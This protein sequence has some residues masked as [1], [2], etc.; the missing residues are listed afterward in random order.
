MQ[1]IGLF[2]AM[3]D[4]DVFRDVVHRARSIERDHRD[5]ILEPGRLQLAQ[6]I[7]HAR[8]L[9]LEHPCRIAP[10]HQLIGRLVIKLELVEF[11]GNIALGHQVERSLEDGQRGQAEEVELDQPGGFHVLHVE[12][13]HPHIRARVTIERYQLIERSIT[14]HDTGSV[15]RGVAVQPLELQGDVE[16]PG[17]GRLFPAHFPQG[18]F[19]VNGFLQGY[20]IGRIVRDQFGNPVN[21]PVRHLQDAANITH[22]HPGLKLTE[23]DNLRDP[24]IAVFLA[25]I[26]DHLI[27]AMLTEID[28]EIGH[29]YPFGIEEALE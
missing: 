22:H 21:L 5:N 14:D 15:G 12:L 17:N 9:K 26:I 7:A 24:V 10:R 27:P 23:G 13:R 20:R 25:H 19:T 4:A 2:L 1:V 29:G 11:D 18:R 16:Q 28:V 3:F 6:G 8:T